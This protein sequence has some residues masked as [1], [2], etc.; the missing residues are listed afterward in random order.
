MQAAEVSSNHSVPPRKFSVI[1]T[2]ID[3][4]ANM[5]LILYGRDGNCYARL[6]G[7]DGLRVDQPE[8]PLLQRP[9]LP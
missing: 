6:R 7:R 2:R 9:D 3:D 5:I 8:D 4:I 1:L